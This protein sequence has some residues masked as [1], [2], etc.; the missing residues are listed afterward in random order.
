MSAAW[1]EHFRVHVA[2]GNDI[3]VRYRYQSEQV[4]LAIPACAMTPTRYV[5]DWSNSGK[6]VASSVES[7]SA[8]VDGFN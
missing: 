2:K 8:A 7:A 3:D 4:A 6:P 1:V 5:F